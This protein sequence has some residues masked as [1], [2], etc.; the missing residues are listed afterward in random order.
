MKRI[1]GNL[2]LTGSLVFLLTISFIGCNNISQKKDE[3]N[4]CVLHFSI[5]SEQEVSS[6]Y[7]TGYDARS[8]KEK[9]LYSKGPEEKKYQTIQSAYL[10]VLNQYLVDRINIG[11]Y[12]EF[13][14]TSGYNFYPLED[15]VYYLNRSYGRKNFYLRNNAYV[16]RLTYEQLDLLEKA[17]SDTDVTISSELQKMVIDTWKDIITVYPDINNRSIYEINYE[18]DAANGFSAYN[19]SLTFIFGLCK[20]YDIDGDY[21]DVNAEKEKL[22][23]AYSVIE[24]FETELSQN[25][26]CHVKVFLL[27]GEHDG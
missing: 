23:I 2:I 9:G 20:E 5:M 15:N 27:V 18:M 4:M 17:I 7:P 25:L 22:T 1:K 21:V 6:I 16:E 24:Q 3:S 13:L 12:E 10:A 19:D 26:D 11:K 8:A 14:Q